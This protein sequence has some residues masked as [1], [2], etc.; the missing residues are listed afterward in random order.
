MKGSVR[1]MQTDT[2]AALDLAAACAAPA[3]LANAAAAALI[4]VALLLFR[5]PDVLKSP[6]M[7]GEN[8]SVLWL[9]H[10][11]LGLAALLKP[12]PDYLNSMGRIGAAIAASFSPASAP[13]VYMLIAAAGV[14][15]A[16]ATAAA[17]APNVRMGLLLAAGLL[18]VPHPSGEVFGSVI[19]LMWIMGPVLGLL[20]CLPPSATMLGRCN[21]FLF[22]AAAS[23]T[24]PFAIIMAPMALL[25]FWRY[26]DA[27]P[28]MALIGAAIQL[29]I[30]VSHFAPPPGS[31]NAPLHLAGTVLSRSLL[32]G[33]LGT[34]ASLALI[35]VS[36]LI[37]RQRELRAGLLLLAVG[38]LLGTWVKFLPVSHILDH[39]FNGSRYFFVPLVALFWCAISLCFSGRRPAAIGIAWLAILA[40][41][42]P[43]GSFVR[44]PLPDYHWS[45]Y[46]GDIGR[47]AVVIPIPPD[48]WSV[49]VPA[50]A[51][52]P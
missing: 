5:A 12:Y 43:T 22:A 11:L 14:A 44:P 42:Y 48:G 8:G 26:R 37:C 40:V 36:L 10:H 24:G 29:A 45:A 13:R 30:I 38:T 18:L 7:F 49:A 3:S 39:P 34:I 9:D 4:A 46:A 2:A 20:L 52:G 17:A 15:W 25:R 50:P 1:D 23:L 21:Q 51:T 41:T 19:H 47:R 27:L 35:I 28:A 16:A 33:S 6:Q 32:Q 31:D